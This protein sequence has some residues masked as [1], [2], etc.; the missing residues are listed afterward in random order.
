VLEDSDLTKSAFDHTNFQLGSTYRFDEQWSVFGGYAT[1]FDVEGTTGGVDA[2]GDPFDPE[3][4]EQF[5]AG[6]R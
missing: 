1:G 3:E 2:N 4:S 5:E 6:L